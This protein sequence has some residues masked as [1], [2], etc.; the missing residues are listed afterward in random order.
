MKKILLLFSLLLA[1]QLQA[2]T[3]LGFQTLPANPTVSDDI[4][5]LVDCR[6]NSSGCSYHTGGQSFFT[7]D[8]IGAWSLH[9]L[10]PLAALC[11]YTDTFH[12]GLLAAGNYSFSFQ[13][14]EGFGGPPCTPGFAPGPDS[15]FVFTVS[16]TTSEKEIEKEGVNIYPNPAINELRIQNA[17][18]RIEEIEIYNV[19]G[20][21][22]FS[23]QIATN[24]Q[25][26]TI[27]DISTL[28]PGMYVAELKAKE[29][30]LRKI[31]SVQ[32]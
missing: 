8:S 26:E 10:G 23:R 31:F 2:Q 7:S 4:Y 13:L 5:V 27:I 17:E 1:S 3:I 30:S 16:L 14:D 12:L 21:E 15:S 29:K 11:D 9:C 20:K 6:F 22:M 24:G 28:T 25:Q 19:I 18:L 32:R